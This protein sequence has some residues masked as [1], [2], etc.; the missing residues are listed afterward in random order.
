M[1]REFRPEPALGRTANQPVTR[2]AIPTIAHMT[3]DK[4]IF[5]KLAA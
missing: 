3:R 1:V 2:M 4:V 5:M